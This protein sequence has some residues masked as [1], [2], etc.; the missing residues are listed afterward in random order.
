[1]SRRLSLAVLLIVGLALP[2]PAHAASHTVRVS[3]A[4]FMFNPASVTVHVGDTVEWTYDETATTIPPGCEFPA[5]QIA[6]VTCPGHSVTSDAM[7]KGKPLFNSGVHRAYGFPFRFR[8]TRTGTYTY[9]CIV[10]GG[11]HP[12]NPATMM[13]GTVIVRR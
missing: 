7:R 13:N 1:M 2:L 6:V 4:S 12:N 8:F 9:Y 3:M 5:L 11:A 10:H